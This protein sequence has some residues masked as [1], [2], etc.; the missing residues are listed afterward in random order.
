M[1]RDT[2]SQPFQ[3]LTRCGCGSKLI[4]PL[5]VRTAGPGCAIVDRRC[6]ECETRDTVVAAAD[7]AAA[8]VHR[9]S[10]LRAVLQAS[11]VSA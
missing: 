7:A 6:P 1:P 8:W 5:A 2:D 11:L 3:P 4:Y 9:Q 10:Y